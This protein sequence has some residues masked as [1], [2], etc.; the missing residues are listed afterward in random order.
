MT[1]MTETPGRRTLSE[2]LSQPRS[3]RECLNALDRQIPAV[4]E[5]FQSSAEALF[6]GCGS[7]FYVAQAAESCW[8]HL[9]GQKARAAPASELL[10]YPELLAPK[11]NACRPVLIS[12]SGA[13]S[14]ILKAA[15]WLEVERNIR[16]LAISCSTRPPLGQI[17]SQSLTLTPA[18][19]QSMVM[20]RSFTSMLLG[21]ELLAASVAENHAYRDSLQ[22]LADQTEPLVEGI[23]AGVESFVAAHEFE[24]YVF[25]GQGPFFGIASEAML[26]VKEMSCSYSQC[27]HTLEFRHGP[28][29]IVSPKVLVT[30]FLSETG[31]EA[32][33]EV[34][35]EVKG[36]GGVTMVVANRPERAVRRSAD[37]LVALDLDVPEFA[38]PAAAVI[39]AQLLGFYTG[40]KKGYDPD[41]PP[42]LSRVVV[43]NN[44]RPVGNL[45]E[46][47]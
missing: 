18:D 26:K 44:S 33:R 11:P 7:S 3:W 31:A 37:H 40:L 9:T 17:A 47:S 13:T 41:R 28:K 8:T 39:A 20:T 43:L 24:D 46:K 35:E 25:L 5:K 19:E 22:R 16:T 21:L 23:R 1:S 32:E 10:L 30:F 2:I 38:R 45:K 6:V 27:F 12:R 34:L 36:L 29:A 42:N 14:E 4:R 15:E